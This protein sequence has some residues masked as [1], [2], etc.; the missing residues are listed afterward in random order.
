MLQFYTPTGIFTRF[1]LA[2]W[3][4]KWNEVEFTFALI[5]PIF[6]RNQQNWL[7]AKWDDDEKFLLLLLPNFKTVSGRISSV[8]HR[9]RLK[10]GLNFL[11]FFR[12]TWWAGHHRRCR[13]YRYSRR[14]ALAIKMNC[15]TFTMDVELRHFIRSRWIAPTWI[16]TA[17]QQQRVWQHHISR[18]WNVI[19][20]ITIIPTL[21]T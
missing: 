17:K 6:C 5:L 8:S 12:S 10:V 4:R 15:M 2:W 18:C 7:H 14:R 3:Y 1:N 11:E 19:R 20:K 9:R 16:S 21:F 13:T